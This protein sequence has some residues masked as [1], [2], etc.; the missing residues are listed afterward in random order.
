MTEGVSQ[1]VKQ[2][3]DRAGKALRA[4]EV[5]L[6]EDLFE[7]AVSRAYYAVLHA[8]R[9]VLLTLDISP[10]THDGVRRMFGLHLVKPG[11]LETE[12]AVILTAEQQDRELGDYDVVF[13][14]EAER[15]QKRVEE[16]KAFLNRISR[17]LNE[18][19]P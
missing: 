11:I 19:M 12:F 17:H 2:E 16:A 7:D 4:A 14:M 8:A 15:A 13:T 3:M 18:S 1:A 5:L 6:D 10:S 9:A